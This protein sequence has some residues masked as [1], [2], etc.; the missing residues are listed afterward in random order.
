M[1]NKKKKKRDPQIIRAEKLLSYGIIFGLLS[2][3]II[4][5]IICF[6]TKNLFWLALTPI[7]T[8]FLGMAIASAI[9]NPK[10]AQ[11]KHSK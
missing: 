9:S 1:S 6:F 2:G 11:K 10:K 5:C 7:I 8:F 4:G 3:I